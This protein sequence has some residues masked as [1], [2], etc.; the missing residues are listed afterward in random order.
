MSRRIP[1]LTVRFYSKRHQQCCVASNRSDSRPPLSFS[2]VTFS[3]GALVQPAANTRNF[4]SAVCSHKKI[5][6]MRGSSEMRN[7]AVVGFG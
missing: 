6:L 2:Y 5:H 4:M 7:D 3:G 1:S